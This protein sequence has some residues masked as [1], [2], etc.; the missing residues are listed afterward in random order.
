MDEDMKD[1]LEK[2]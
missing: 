1:R 2:I